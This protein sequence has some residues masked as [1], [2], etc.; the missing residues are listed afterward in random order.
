[1][2][3]GLSSRNIL[4]HLTLLK[5]DTYGF[6]IFHP[7][8]DLKDSEKLS[9]FNEMFDDLVLQGSGHGASFS[10]LP[11]LWMVQLRLHHLERPEMK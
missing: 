10:A 6:E 3:S 11:L 1:M 2:M 8:E 9:I 7:L 5:K 4:G